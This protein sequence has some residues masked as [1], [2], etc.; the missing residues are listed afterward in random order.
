MAVSFFIIARSY[1]ETLFYWESSFSL[2]SYPAQISS[3]IYAQ[4]SVELSVYVRQSNS[5]IFTEIDTTR[6]G[7]VNQFI[8]SPFN[9]NLT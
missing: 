1:V 5:E 9:H 2:S 7:V 6:F 3:K 8:S 4:I